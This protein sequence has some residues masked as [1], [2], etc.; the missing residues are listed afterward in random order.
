LHRFQEAILCITE[1]QEQK[2]IF[3]IVTTTI[4]HVLERSEKAR[5]QAGHLL[6]DIVKRNIISVSD[7]LKG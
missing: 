3:E 5:Q 6:H 2:N 4:N 7:Y 1:L